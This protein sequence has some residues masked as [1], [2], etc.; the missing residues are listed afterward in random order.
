MGINRIAGTLELCKLMSVRAITDQKDKPGT[1]GMM[2][3]RAD[4]KE[5]I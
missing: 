5:L 2:N 4:F 1:T 3:G